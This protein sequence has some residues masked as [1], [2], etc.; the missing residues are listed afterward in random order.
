ML[1]ISDF[2]YQFLKF[3]PDKQF[4]KTFSWHNTIHYLVLNNGATSDMLLVQVARNITALSCLQEKGNRNGMCFGN[5]VIYSNDNLFF[6]KYVIQIPYL[7]LSDD[8]YM[9]MFLK[10]AFVFLQLIC[11]SK[12]TPFQLSWSEEQNKHCYQMTQAV[13]SMV[14]Q[15]IGL[16]C[17]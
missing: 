3:H 12:Q 10:K 4:L 8:G 11:F 5:Q 9:Y 7:I 17:K 2:D 16:I 14:L 6:N 13:Y 1:Y 15:M